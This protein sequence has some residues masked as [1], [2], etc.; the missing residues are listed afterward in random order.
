[1]TD[2]TARHPRLAQL[3]ARLAP[4]FFELGVDSA[5]D[6]LFTLHYASAGALDAVGLAPVA[7]HRSTYRCA[8]LAGALHPDDRDRVCAL[9]R[10]SGRNNLPFR[11]QCRVTARDAAERWV[12]LHGEPSVNGAAAADGL[13]E[14]RSGRAVVWRVIATDITALKDVVEQ[15]EVQHE[16]LALATKVGGIGIWEVKLPGGEFLYNETMHEIYG[17]EPDRGFRAGIPPNTFGSSGSGEWVKVI[18]PDDVPHV[19]EAI[20]RVTRELTTIEYGH[21]I[22]RTS[23]E[24]R[25]VRSAARVLLDEG[26]TPVGAI[27]TTLDVTEHSRLTQALAKEK[28]RLVLAARAGQIGIWENDFTEGRFIWDDQMHTLY[29]MP[30]GSFGGRLEDWIPLLHPDDA[31]RVLAAWETAL[32]E[33]NAIDTE[34]RVVRPSGEIVRIRAIVQVTPD[35]DGTPRRALG[36]NWDV[37][38]AHALT[39][40]LRVEKET[41]ERAERAK[42]EFLAVMSHEIRTPMNTVLGMARLSLQTDLTPRQRNYVSKIDISARNLVAILND[43]LD[44][45]KIEAGKMALEETTFTLESV[46]ESVAAVTAIK[47]EEKGLEIAFSVAPDVPT[48]LVGDPLRIGQ[49]LIN[50]VNNAV[51]FTERGEVVVSIG[52]DH[53]QADGRAATPGRVM[54]RVS[55]RDTGIGLERDQIADLF[56]AFSQA[57]RRTSRDYGGTGLGLAISRQLVELMGGRIWADGE[58]GRGSTFT[59]TFDLALANDTPM[60]AAYES[61]PGLTGRRVLIVDD[62][63]SAREILVLMVRRFGMEAAAVASGAAALALLREADAA[64]ARFELVLMDWRMP[65]MDGLETARQIKHDTRLHGTP[66]VLM[67]TAYGREEV[68]TRAQQLGLEGV[69]IKPVTESVLFNPIADALGCVHAGA[70]ERRAMPP[71]SLTSDPLLHGPGIAGLAGRRVLVVDDNALN[72][73]VATEWLLAAGMQVDAAIHGRDALARIRETTYDVVL[74]DVHMPEMDGLT[75]AREIRKQPH[76]ATLPIVALTAQAQSVDREASLAAGMNAHLTKPIDEARL[77]EMLTQMLTPAPPVSPAS[78]ASSASTAAA[79]T[80]ADGGPEGAAATAAAAAGDAGDG[81]ESLPQL[82]IAAALQILGGRRPLL[83]R[84]LRSFARDFAQVPAQ[85]EQHLAGGQR[86]EVARLAHT[87][88]SAA[89]YVGA[90]DLS[91]ASAQL[92][93]ATRQGTDEEMAERV[94]VFGAYLDA[95]LRGIA[96]LSMPALASASRRRRERLAA[97]DRPALLAAIAAAEPLVAGG[98]YAAVSR[99]DEIARLAADTPLAPI[100]DAIR[101][102]FEEIDLEAAMGSLR[103]LRV[104]LA[105]GVGAAQP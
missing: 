48:R 44:F 4:H 104:T 69:L 13:P 41:A 57:E 22:F 82:D 36:I 96:V 94:L 18:H 64:R 53:D 91:A 62:N 87:I 2:T 95:L 75:A 27:G 70:A 8:D 97:I 26:G 14:R 93:E 49:V 11:T 67:V 30:P 73:E 74:M 101:N 65:G 54:W 3:L 33:T 103:R 61:D 71:D 5:D 55:V 43:I 102:Q 83:R 20:D 77:Y 40:A 78:S 50:L 9:V 28:E 25:D 16:R 58:P 52:L 90:L 29:G 85:L 100:A 51:K 19:L 45:S 31:P 80:T 42:S 38:A 10:D 84:L 47:A 63:A 37:T 21:R 6:G 92:E 56:E 60:P 72:R 68:L 1:M 88:K 79:G 105:D 35:E 89:A 24:M 32:G 86:E 17:L 46:L 98:D 81:L 66:A 23:G 7:G 34:F 39:E 15:L 76:L 12:D 99:L 59:C